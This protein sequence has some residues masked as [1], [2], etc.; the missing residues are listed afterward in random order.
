MG[1]GENIENLDI[2]ECLLPIL[3]ET[4]HTYVSSSAVSLVCRIGEYFTSEGHQLG[5][6]S[7]IF[8]DLGHNIGEEIS[9][10]IVSLIDEATFRSIESVIYI[11]GSATR[12]N[13]RYSN[14]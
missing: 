2:K 10:Q 7:D 9:L 3:P 1:S 14:Q 4:P 11:K 6:T 13:R 12:T 8:V 5:F